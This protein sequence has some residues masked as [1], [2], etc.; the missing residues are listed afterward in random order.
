MKSFL[1][2]GR[3]SSYLDDNKRL[4]YQIALRFFKTGFNRER[5]RIDYRLTVGFDSTASS[6][7]LLFTSDKRLGFDG[8]FIVF[9]L[10]IFQDKQ[11]DREYSMLQATHKHFPGK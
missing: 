2:L 11:S 7:A 9:Y 6:M 1:V 5:S 4:Y 8:G 10:L 3:H